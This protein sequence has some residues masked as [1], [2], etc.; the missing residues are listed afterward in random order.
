MDEFSLI[1]TYLKSIPHTRD[2]VI[3]GIGDDC[4]CLQ[5]PPEMQLLISCDTLV[6]NVHF[7]PTWDAYDIA[8]RAV[9][10]N[11]SDVAA[12][13]GVPCWSMLALTLPTIDDAWMQR[14]SC[15]FA[16]ALNRYNIALI[17]GDMTRGPLSM[18][19]TIHGQIP[20]GKAVQR[21]GARAGDTI[22][23]TGVLG[24]AALAVD[25]L[26]TPILDEQDKAQLMERLLRP[27]PRTDLGSILQH[28]AT[29]AIDISDGLS[30]DL[31]HICKAS[32]VGA[33]LDQSMIP[34]HPLFAKYK[35]DQA[36]DFVLHGGDD[37][38]LCFTVSP[39][40]EK[41]LLMELTLQGL[42][43][44]PVGVIEKNAGLRMRGPDGKMIPL[45]ARGYRHF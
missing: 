15:G 12:M 9:M 6:E 24:G 35:Q 41:N 38:E 37:Y 18:T 14:F 17:G 8:W 2:D 1:N 5:V 43:C 20:K 28:Y 26:T 42:T 3:F 25:A 33:C 45:E 44:Y 4:A 21:S 22:F 27:I 13:G 10:V 16:E 32:Q 29:A 30:S 34:M 23:V 7:L 39:Q 11:I 19:L 40:D 36:L 31:Q